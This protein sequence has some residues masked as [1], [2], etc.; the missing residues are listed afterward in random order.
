MIK[1]INY[2][3]NKNKYRKIFYDNIQK[4]QWH[5]RVPI[6]Q[7]LF[8]Y[9]LMIPDNHFLKPFIEPVEK[10][11]NILGMNNYPRFSY[12]FPNTLLRHHVDEDN[13]VSININLLSTTPCI[14]IEHD[15]YE[16]E[17]ALINV[18]KYQHGVE[19]DP[20]CRLIL[21][22]CLRHSWDDVCERIEH[23]L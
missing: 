21:K 19:P 11:L 6:R 22:F 15:P 17:C 3:I 12:Q 16:Y 13:M 9:Q 2:K 4:G 7:E 14:H 1:H 23:L 20:N 5:W 8:W 10:D 18:G